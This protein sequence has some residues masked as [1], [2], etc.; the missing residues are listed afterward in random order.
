[1]F[2]YQ[3]SPTKCIVKSVEIVPGSQFV[4]YWKSKMQVV[5]TDKGSF[6]DNLP[7][8]KFTNN[9]TAHPGFDWKSLEGQEVDDFQIIDYMGFQWINKE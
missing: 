1:M 6:I 2:E 8:N 7:G 9:K 5:E 4:D 3:K